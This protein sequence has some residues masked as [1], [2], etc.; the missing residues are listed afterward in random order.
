MGSIIYFLSAPTPLDRRIGSLLPGAAAAIAYG[1]T[2][3]K[4]KHGPGKNPG[5]RRKGEMIDSD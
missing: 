2:L 3:F 5:Q 4:H 1:S